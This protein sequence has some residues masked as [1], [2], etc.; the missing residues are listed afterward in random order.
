MT[1]KPKRIPALQGGKSIKP[2][3]IYWMRYVIPAMLFYVIFM[4]YPM[5]DSIRL[6]LYEGTAGVREYVGLA[7]YVRLFTDEVVSKRFWNAFGNN[8]IFFAYHMILQNALGILFA[9]ILTNRTMKG[10]KF[11]QTLIFIPCTVAVLVT[12]YLFKIMMNPQWSKAP[13]ESVGL[14]FLVHSPLGWLGDHGTALSAV[15]LVSVWQWVG[16]PTMMFVAAFQSIDDD[17]LEAASIEGASPWQ[18][19]TRIRVPLIIPVI[20]MVAIL[21]FVANFNAFDV[22]FAMETPEGAPDYAT[23][24]I[25]TL[26]YRYGVAGQH[27]VGIPEPGLGSA[28]STTIFAMLLCGVVPVLVKTQGKE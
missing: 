22:V 27:P 2:G 6:S 1:V 26:F 4:A 3:G 20:G 13:L 16:I 18:Q 9:A 23:D 7:N 21:T 5:L 25:G 10:R 28:I 14:G 12:G 11:Y 15:S 8:W 17:L 19:F 24:L